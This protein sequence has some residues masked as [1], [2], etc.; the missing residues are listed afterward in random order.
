VNHPTSRPIPAN[1]ALDVTQE[2]PS[3]GDRAAH[4]PAIHLIED[5]SGERRDDLSH[6]LYKRLRLAA[7]VLFGVFAAFA[8]WALW[9]ADFSTWLNASTVLAQVATTL[10][11]GLVAAA[12]C[13][14]STWSPRALHGWEFLAF[15]APTLF[16]ALWQYWN[17]VNLSARAGSYPSLE[18]GWLLLVFIYALFI[19]S[20]WKRAA[21]V[22]GVIATAA[23]GIAPLAAWTDSQAN[24]AL[25]D[26]PSV[27]VEHL[28]MAGLAAIAAVVGV[29]TINSLRREVYEA[30]QLGQYRLKRLLGSGGMGE[31][32]LA[33]HQMMKRP[34]AVKVIRAEKAGDPTVLARFEREVQATAKLSHWNS[35]DIFDYGRTDEGTF[36][37]VMEYLP[38]MHLGEL[39][40]Q[41]GPLPA[42]RVIYLARQACQALQEAHDLD[43]IHRDI[44]PANLFAAVRGGLYDVLKVLDFGLAKPLTDLEGEPLTQDGTITGSPLYMAPEQASGDQEADPRSDLY[45]L[46]AVLYFLV[47]G[48][49]PFEGDKPLKVLIAHASEPPTPP[50]QIHPG[51]PA[52]LEQVILRCLAKKPEQRYASAEALEEALEACAAARKWDR[53]AARHWWTENMPG[54]CAEDQLLGAA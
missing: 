27:L 47:T 45:S 30:R 17:I 51:V 44:K 29:Q 14:R 36:Y 19:P 38:G 49:P 53:T 23:F 54:K 9:N 37:Y 18:S 12:L 46:G 1:T 13:A 39:V 50:S 24:S 20:T 40:R 35:I 4:L 42:S 2:A 41:F 11:L 43:L 33:E 31:V 7:V 15:A 21:C 10:I 34:C 6:L 28:L 32:Y 48:R 3:L 16:M 52:D 26:R 5:A 8:P 25:W 22:V